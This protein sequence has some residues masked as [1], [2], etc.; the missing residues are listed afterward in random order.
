MRGSLGL[1]KIVR[2]FPKEIDPY[3]FDIALT[4]IKL[5]IILYIGANLKLVALSLKFAAVEKNT[6]CT[7]QC[8]NKPAKSI[9]VNV[10]NDAI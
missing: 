7:V 9:A 2:W 1:R 4:R 3:C 5:N 6:L 8:N 10:C